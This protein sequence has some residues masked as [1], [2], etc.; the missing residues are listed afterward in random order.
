MSNANIR[1]ECLRPAERWTQPSGEEIREVLHLAGFTGGQA[2]RVL[3]LGTKGD[4]TVRRWIG[5]QS[6]IPYAAWAILCDFAGLGA[7]WKGQG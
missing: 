6:A 7:I 2:A 3:G 5:E 4:R 1:L